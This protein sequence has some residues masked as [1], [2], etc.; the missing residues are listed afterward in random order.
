MKLNWIG[1]NVKLLEDIVDKSTLR[2]N[3]GASLHIFAGNRAKVG[4]DL[5]LWTFVFQISPCC[6]GNDFIFD[7][8]RPKQQVARLSNR[9]EN[10][11]NWL[12]R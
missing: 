7:S 10:T 2:L 3:L 6:D 9:T 1:L 5:R 11:A 12:R 8:M 4:D